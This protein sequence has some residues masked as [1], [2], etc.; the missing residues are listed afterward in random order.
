LK[1]EIAAIH[2]GKLTP[3]ERGSAWIRANKWC[4]Q[5]KTAVSV[6]PRINRFGASEAQK[7]EALRMLAEKDKLYEDEWN[8]WHK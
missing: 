2:S 4:G 5:V 1:K 7:K 8:R 3:R 6:L